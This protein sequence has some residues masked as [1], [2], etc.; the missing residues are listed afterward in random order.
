[1]SESSEEQNATYT[2]ETVAKITRLSTE[3]IVLYYREGLV[4]PVAPAEPLL[5]DDRAVHQLRRIAFL[6]SEYELNH[7]GLRTMAA[8]MN[9]VENLRA[10]LRFLRERG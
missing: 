6:L 5:F 3:R 2:V 7:R 1:M 9:E 10:E 8:L 4:E